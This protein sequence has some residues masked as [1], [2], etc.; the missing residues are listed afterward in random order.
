MSKTRDNVIRRANKVFETGKAIFAH[1]DCFNCEIE[2]LKSISFCTRDDEV[3]S[4]IKGFRPVPGSKDETD[5]K[6]E[7]SL[8]ILH[9]GNGIVYAGK[10]VLDNLSVW[11]LGECSDDFILGRY[12]IGDD[13][14][15]IRTL[16]SQ[17]VERLV[18]NLDEA[19]SISKRILQIITM[20]P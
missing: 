19:D 15:W 18:A 16:T 6:I 5:I 1:Y 12:V 4:V 10:L 13:S 8:E 7:V 11:E 9:L 14:N 17:E 20:E 3:L 2:I